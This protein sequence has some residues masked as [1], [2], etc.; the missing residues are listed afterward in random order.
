MARSGLIAIGVAV[1]VAAAAAL[2]WLRAEEG[3]GEEARQRPPARVVLAEAEAARLVR[4][5]DAIGTL[6]ATDSVML[7]ARIPG[8]IAEI[9]FEQGQRVEAGQVLIRLEPEEAWA[10]LLAAEAEAAEIRQQLARAERLAGEGFGPRAE[11]EDLRH[12]LEAARARIALA[13]LRYNETAILAPFAGRVGLHRVS[14]G[15]LVQPGTELVALDAVDP[16]AL[17]F[18]V[19]EQQ[20]P[21]IGE[22][23][24]VWARSPALPGGE[25][26]ARLSAIDTRVDPRLRT[27]MMEARLPN[28]EGRL[29][30]GMLLNVRIAAEVVEDAVVVPP[31]AVLM[32]GPVHFVFRVPPGAERAERVEVRIGERRPERV[33]VLAGLAPG[34]RVVVEGHQALSDGDPVVEL[35]RDPDGRDA[36]ARAGS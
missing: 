25:V 11:M 35:R 12:R 14:P 7:T 30:P 32:T 21:R 9:L 8:R 36:M 5:V 4:T 26:K 19:P 2:L 34:D 18:A 23:A 17:R 20:A 1:A 6:V 31:M 27:V 29:R 22:G 15:A 28:P 24:T 33:E 13:R 3:A 16:I 10:E